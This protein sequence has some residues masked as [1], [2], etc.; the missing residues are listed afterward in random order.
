MGS[1][2]HYMKSV[3][4]LAIGG[5]RLVAIG[6]WWLVAIGGCWHWLVVGDWCWWGLVVGGWWRLVAVG[7]SWRLAVV[8]S[9]WGWSLPKKKGFLKDRPGKPCAM[10]GAQMQ[11]LT[12]TPPKRFGLPKGV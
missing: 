8:G 6:S 12:S 10:G 7:S 11:P 3:C 1:V 4:F 2:R 9:P 5:W